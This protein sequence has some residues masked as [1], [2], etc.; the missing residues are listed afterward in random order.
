M[1]KLSG[2]TADSA[3][4]EKIRPLLE[5]LIGLVVNAVTADFRVEFEQEPAGHDAA[6]LADVIYSEDEWLIKKAKL[7]STE[8]TQQ[9]KKNT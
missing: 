3:N 1:T 2:H 9:I 5:N 8:S 6:V 4:L 7:Q